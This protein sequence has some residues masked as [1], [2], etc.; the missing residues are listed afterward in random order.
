[1]D[2]TPLLT[3]LLGLGASP[4][5]RT[6]KG[7]TPLMVAAESGKKDAIA[8]LLRAGANRDDKSPEVRKKVVWCVCVVLVYYALMQTSAWAAFMPRDRC[9]Y[10]CVA[11]A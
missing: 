9:V 8:A 3:S 1:M 5:V 4:S 7:L 11:Y 6:P 10:V 2:S